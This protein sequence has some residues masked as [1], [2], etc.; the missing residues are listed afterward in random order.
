MKYAL[1]AILLHNK[2]NNKINFLT[3]KKSKNYV[4]TYNDID[5]A[6]VIKMYLLDHNIN[7]DIGFSIV[8]YNNN[9]KNRDNK[10]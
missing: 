9:I 5:K 6:K 2:K 7:K 8:T 3:N 4:I 10:S 1:Y